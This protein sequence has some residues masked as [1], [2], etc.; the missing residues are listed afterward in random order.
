MSTMSSELDTTR[1]LLENLGWTHAGGRLAEV[2]EAAVRQSQSLTGFLHLLAT[3]EHEAREQYRVAAWLKRSG[4]PVGKTLESFDFTFARGLE[5]GKVELLATCEFATRQENVLILGPSGVGKTHLAAGLGVKV[6]ANG[7]AASFVLADQLLDTLRQDEAA[8]SKQSSRRRYLTAKVLIID[9]LGFQAM[10][11]ADAHRF[12]R[13]INYRYERGST[14]LTSNKSIREWPEMF[15]GDEALATAILDRLLHH[16]HV[17]SI[18]G[19]S[20]RLKH[21]AEPVRPTRAKMG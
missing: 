9:E 5:K 3:A 21:L 6:I 16:C 7:F 17:V 11:K 18:D 20:Y 10:D 13:L 19:K 1:T 8:P 14:I 2:L 15:A 4:L 12:F